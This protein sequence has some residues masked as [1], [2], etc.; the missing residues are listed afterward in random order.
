[1][2]RNLHSKKIINETSV[3]DIKLELDVRCQK[4]IERQLHSAFPHISF[5]GEEGD[6]GDRQAEYRWVVDPID[7]TVNFTYGIPHA[8]VSIAL[9]QRSA[10]CQV[11]GVRSKSRTTHHA[12][13]N[14]DY[15]TIAGVVYDPFQDELWTAICGQPARLNGKVIRVSSRRTLGDAV[16]SIGFS[17]SRASM[18]H[19]LPYFAWLARR[20][21]KIRMMGAAALGLTYVATGRFDA[22]IERGINLWD[23]AAGGLI[24]ECAGGEFW[25]E[26]ISGR[27][28]RMIA[29]NGLL[30]R[31]LRT[32]KFK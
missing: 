31:T 15:L 14:A 22:Y 20:V 7:G 11:S 2:R 27:K 10:R 6:S 1:M 26:P 5:L 17:K 32:G 19:A 29:S 28:F 25:H 13:L 16:V 23:I 12:P 30:G 24:V 9:Q 21:R 3:H 8:C 4:L 18:E